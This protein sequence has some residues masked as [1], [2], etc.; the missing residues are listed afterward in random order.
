MQLSSSRLHRRNPR[1]RVNTTIIAGNQGVMCAWNSLA[2]LLAALFLC[3]LCHGWS[4]FPMR[5]LYLQQRNIVVTPRTQMTTQIYF[6]NCG[7]FSGPCG[8]KTVPKCW[9]GWFL[10]PWKFGV[11]RRTGILLYLRC[12]NPPLQEPF[13]PRWNRVKRIVSYMGRWW[14]AFCH[15]TDRWSFSHVTES[16][17]FCHVTEG[18][19]SYWW[20]DLLIQS[21]NG[22][23][24]EHF[25]KINKT[26]FNQI[27]TFCRFLSAR[28]TLVGLAWYRYCRVSLKAVSVF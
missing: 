19:Q 23:K 20:L 6:A 15:V 11:D 12:S 10:L 3:W 5:R 9:K 14:C 16:W 24:C 18:W 13:S 21:K 17:A 22:N 8:L 7:D 2:K 27:N 4:K 28:K 1:N 25:V 26:F